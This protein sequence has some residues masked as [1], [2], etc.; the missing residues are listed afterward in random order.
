MMPK[1]VY[2]RR[3]RS[4][5][6]VLASMQ[7]RLLSMCIPEPNSGCWIFTGCL[8][9]LGYGIMARTKFVRTPA[10]RASYEVFNG[11]IPDGMDVM[12]S[13]DVRCCVNPEH[14][15]TG[16]HADNMADM[17]RK[18]RGGSG[19]HHAGECAVCGIR[20]TGGHRALT[21]SKACSRAR[22][23]LRRRKI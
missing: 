14:L 23:N 4:N 6:E 9:S 11:P 2:E 7:S 15:T 17:A 16:T 1:G 10:H 8:S 22:Y 5:A 12:H 13:C 3:K 21:C 20:F 18:G 19:F